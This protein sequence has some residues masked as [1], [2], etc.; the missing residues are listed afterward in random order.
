MEGPFN[1]QEN[2]DPLGPDINPFEDPMLNAAENNIENPPG[3][4][5]PL[6]ENQQPFIDDLAMQLDA[7]EANVENSPPIPPQP[8][9]VEPPVEPGIEETDTSQPESSIPTS[10]STP[11]IDQSSEDS[12][13]EEV[14]NDNIHGLSDLE[15]FFKQQ[16]SA[17]TTRPPRQQYGDGWR[18]GGH[19]RVGG[20][21]RGR[22]TGTKG[23]GGLRNCPD[24]RDLVNEDKCNS[25]EKYRHWPEG[26]DEE[27]RGC[28]YDWQLQSPDDDS[29]E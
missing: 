19:P 28:W 13:E 20:S 14:G 5:D 2:L 16:R 3:F 25:C 27:P 23:S 29:E 6:V 9:P 10:P 4:I 11:D 1:P 21:S 22:R 18:Q 7:L 17:P 15:R 24:S 12:D 26:T 8:G